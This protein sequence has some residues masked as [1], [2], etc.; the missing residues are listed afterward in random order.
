M[1]SKLL[2]QV[3]ILIGIQ[4]SRSWIISLAHE[5]SLYNIAFFFFYF[6]C[7]FCFFVMEFPKLCCTFYII[8]NFHDKLLARYWQENILPYHFET[9]SKLFHH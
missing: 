9:E 8:F 1:R 6:F 4:S 2:N 3:N 7:F 5:K